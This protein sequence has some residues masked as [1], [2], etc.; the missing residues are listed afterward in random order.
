MKKGDGKN[1]KEL[2]VV[3]KKG[4]CRKNNP[5]DDG[6]MGVELKTRDVTRKYTIV[7]KNILRGME[8]YVWE[9]NILGEKY[10]KYNKIS[11]NS[12]NF[13]EARLLL[14]AGGRGAL[15]SLA[16]LSCGPTK[17]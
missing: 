2:G 12:E 15:L 13:K 14:V 10:T 17:S 16:L 3:G 6:K 1:V 9:K 7:R 11:N 4:I 8:T 5:E